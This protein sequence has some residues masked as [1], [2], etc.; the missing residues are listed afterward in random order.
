MFIFIPCGAHELFVALSVINVSLR[1]NTKHDR[2]WSVD[3]EIPCMHIKYSYYTC[4]ETAAGRDF[5]LMW[6]THE[7]IIHIKMDEPRKH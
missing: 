4:T 2:Q 3:S 7:C 6:R 1:E 5:M